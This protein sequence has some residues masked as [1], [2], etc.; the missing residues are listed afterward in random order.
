M[1]KQ[2]FGNLRTHGQDRIQGSHRFLKDHRNFAAAFRPHLIF[3][4]GKNI[5]IFKENLA[6]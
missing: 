4:Q 2:C 1:N 3:R 6:I 5:F